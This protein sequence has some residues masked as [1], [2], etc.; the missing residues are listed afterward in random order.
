MITNFNNLAD[1]LKGITLNGEEI[2]AE[3]LIELHS[4]EEQ[5]ELEIGEG[6]FLNTTQETEL[7]ENLIKTGYND[8]KV[9][10]EEMT[11]KEIKRLKGL[12]FEGKTIEN[13]VSSYDKKVM[14]E[15]GAEPT[16]KVKELQ[17]S[18]ETLQGK[19]QND[20][21]AKEEE[22][23]ALNGK[24][25]Q[26][27]IDSTVLRDA[28][29]LEGIKPEHALLIF[30]QSHQLD[31]ED[32]TG[33][34]VKD[35]FGNVIKNELESPMS[36]KDVFTN[37]AKENNWLGS[38]DGRGGENQHGQSNGS[39]KTMNDIMKHMEKENIDPTSKEGLAMI[40]SFNNK[41]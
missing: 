15:A 32:G 2:T 13:L 28:P 14:T 5:F 26:I 6:K 38:P 9:A 29:K 41:A 19:Y 27:D 1:R 20:I 31:K 12:D 37:F 25:K 23:N 40:D 33:I 10:G 35:S 21:K 39:F 7:R 22:L 3:K 24:I 11:I 17:S 16:A 36:Y 34:I 8:G 18:L 30:K 4:S